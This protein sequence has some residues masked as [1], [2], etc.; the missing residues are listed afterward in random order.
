MVL[1]WDDGRDQTEALAAAGLKPEEPLGEPPLLL[2]ADCMV[3]VDV[4]ALLTT[5]AQYA[6]MGGVFTGL[7]YEA[8][9]VV[10][11]AVGIDSSDWPGVFSDLRVME[12]HAVKLG[13]E[14]G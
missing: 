2:P 12:L 7:R 4:F 6:G 14:K 11:E 10:R 5:Q 8:L 13:S 9:S 3:A 1:G